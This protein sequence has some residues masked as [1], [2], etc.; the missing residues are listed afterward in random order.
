MLFKQYHGTIKGMET[1]RVVFCFDENLVAQVQAAAASLLDARGPE[2]HFEIHCVCTE[3]AGNV[4]API[5]RVIKTRDSDSVL[6][7]HCV[8]NPYRNAYQV[9]DI[10]AGT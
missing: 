3:A 2:D 10:S 6:V 9:R 4:Q 7:T 1:L 5:E 8:D